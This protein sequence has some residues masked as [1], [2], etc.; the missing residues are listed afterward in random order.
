M[1]PRHFRFWPKHL[2]RGLT[3]PQVT[4]TDLLEGSARRFPDKPFS[5]FFGGVLTY[6]EALERVERLAGFLQRDCGVRPGDRVLL[7]LQNSPQFALAYY[8]ILRADAVAVPVNPM[9][10]AEELAVTIEDSD[11]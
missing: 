2:P 4:L 9:N 10:V 3:L 5:L 7:D 1:E 11:A 8:A 6:R